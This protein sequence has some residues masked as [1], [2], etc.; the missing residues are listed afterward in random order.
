[1][2][3][4]P[5]ATVSFPMGDA[6]AAKGDQ[7]SARYAWQWV[8][9]DIGLG[10]KVMEPLYVGAYIN[11]GVG[12][13]G[14]DSKT[15]GRCEAGDGVEDDMSCSSV[16]WHAGFEAQ[17]TFSPAQSMSGWLGYGAGITTGSQTI[18][19]AGRYSE[20]STARGYD[21]ARV[22]GGLSFRLTKG[23][24]LTPFA[25]VTI[26]QYTHTRTEI[27]NIVKFSGA[28]S[29]TALHAWLTLGLR[30]VIFP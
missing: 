6:T 19:D 27:H 18:S 14:S 11:L 24:G 9:L 22:S 1:M 2:Y 5:V 28:I 30:V 23:F 7:L 16:T 20:T 15:E 4:T 8:P 17:Y 10:A 21:Y 25:M 12:A 26:G 29:D 13:E 3:V